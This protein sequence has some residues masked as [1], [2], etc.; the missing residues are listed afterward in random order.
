MTLQQLRYVIAVAENGS[1]GKAAQAL[2]I[3][4]PSLTNAIRDLEQ[5]LGFALFNRTNR[6]TA[7]TRDGMRFLA[8]ARQVCEQME[9]LEN[10]FL[11]DGY[12]KLRFQVSAQHYSF[13][14]NA[15]VDLIREYP[16]SEYDVTLRE[17]RTFEVIED[18]KNARSALGI[19]YF[20]RFNESV[21]SGV[22]A[23]NHLLFTHLFTAAPHVF[24]SSGHPLAKKE[25]VTLEELEEYPC[26]SYE[27]GEYNSFYFAEEI[28]STAKRRKQIR[29]SDRATL[30]NL[31]IG[32]NGY[33]ICTGVISRELNGDSIISVPLSAD[34]EIRIGYICR[35]GEP[36][37]A[38]GERYLELMRRHIPQDNAI[39]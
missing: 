10:A 38:L 31:L 35:K 18:V 25:R 16:G 24:L 2:F 5:E 8:Y 3:S 29:V 34:E 9:L 32:M 21:L 13:A 28:L 23:E 15:F 37:G 17:C 11:H 4:Q 1:I 12:E 33:T 27:Q 36:L 7:V 22:L 6:G 39:A 30:F 19:I 14:V 26:L 20:S